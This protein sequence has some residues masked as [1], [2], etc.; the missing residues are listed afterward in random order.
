MHAYTLHYALTCLLPASDC[1]AVLAVQTL[2]HQSQCLHTHSD[3]KADCCP[4]FVAKTSSDNVTLGFR[5]G[6]G[7]RGEIAEKGGGKMVDNFKYKPGGNMAK[8]IWLHN[9]DPA[10]GQE[11]SSIVYAP[12][13]QL[14]DWLQQ[15]AQQSGCCLRPSTTHAV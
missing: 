4:A 12:S 7:G 14:S 15:L 13:L 3:P 5:S 8:K 1:V 10:D 9:S 2:Q 6:A 11:G